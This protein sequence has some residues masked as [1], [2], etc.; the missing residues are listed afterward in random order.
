MT[1]RTYTFKTIVCELKERIS[2]ASCIQVCFTKSRADFPSSNTPQ[3]P[4]RARIRLALGV[5]QMIRGGGNCK[6]LKSLFTKL[7]EKWGYIG[8]KLC[9]PLSKRK[10]GLFLVRSKKKSL[11]RGKN[12]N[13]P[14]YVSSAPLFTSRR[15]S[16]TSAG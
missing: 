6:K 8:E 11:H 1:Y 2:L 7:A 5:D 12:H 4:A 16:E 3:T 14:P 9:V 13:P 10:N 15:Q